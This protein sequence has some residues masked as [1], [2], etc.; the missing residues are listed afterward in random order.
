[1]PLPERLRSDEGGAGA[2]V[3]VRPHEG[4]G[5][6]EVPDRARRGVGRGPVRRLLAANLDAEAPR[7]GIKT[8]V[9]RHDASERGELRQCG[10]RSQ[11][12]V[13]QGW[14]RELGTEEADVRR[15]GNPRVGGAARN[16][17]TR[18][19][20]RLKNRLAHPLGNT[21]AG[22]SLN[23]LSEDIEPLVRVDPALL[24]SRDRSAPLKRQARGMGQ[25]VTDRRPLGPRRIVEGHQASLDRD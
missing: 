20:Q 18:H 3:T 4:T 17:R 24:G 6:P 2:K 5:L 25:Q 11:G 1:M 8:P 19:P 21:D 16:I 12:A 22:C 10:K 7:T 15:T 13:H 9:A 23:D 14:A